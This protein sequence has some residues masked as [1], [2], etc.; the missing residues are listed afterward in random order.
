MTYFYIKIL[1]CHLLS[2]KTLSN[3]KQPTDWFIHWSIHPM[4]DSSNA[5]LLSLELVVAHIVLRKQWWQTQ[6]LDSV[7]RSIGFSSN[8]AEGCMAQWKKIISLIIITITQVLI[9]WLRI[10]LRSAG[11][12]GGSE[13]HKRRGLASDT[14]GKTTPWGTPNRRAVWK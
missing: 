14:H 12:V 1:I 13:F 8:R 5:A 9:K 2:V 4:T 6:R 10:H 3:R 7:P 11:T